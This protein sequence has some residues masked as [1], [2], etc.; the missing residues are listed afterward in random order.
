MNHKCE[1]YPLKQTLQY[2]VMTK[3]TLTKH[4]QGKQNPQQ[5]AENLYMGKWLGHTPHYY[6]YFSFYF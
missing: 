4:Q 3:K 2:T 6:Y 1:S 5:N